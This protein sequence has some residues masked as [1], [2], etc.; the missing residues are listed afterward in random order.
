MSRRKKHK[1]FSQRGVALLAVAVCMTIIAVIASGFDQ[2]TRTD[3]IAATT[4]RDRMRA[5]F[6]ARS[7]M[8]LGELVIR[9]QKDLIDNMQVGDIQI[10]D[11]LI[12]GEVIGLF[13][14]SEDNLAGSMTMQYTGMSPEMVKGLGLEVGHF[15]L[16]IISEGG[17]INVNCANGSQE[18]R[19]VLKDRLDALF[20]PQAYDQ[21]FENETADGYRRTR[22]EQAAAIIDYIDRD[23]SLF[24]SPGT[25]E[26]YGYRSLDDDYEAKNNY[27]DTVGELQMVRGIDDRFWAVFGDAFTVYGSCKVNIKAVT[28]PNIIASIILLAAKDPQD[29]VVQDPKRLY[30]LAKHVAGLQASSGFLS[31]IG[32]ALTGAQVSELEAFANKVANPQGA[33][34]SMF[35]GLEGAPEPAPLVGEDGIRIE[36]VE[37]D[38]QKLGR[39]AEAGPRRI[40]RI[41]SSAMIGQIQVTI[42]GVW[43]TEVQNQ[44]PR[45]PGYDKGTW[46]LWREL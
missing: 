43:D 28:D 33:L 9:V 35:A 18:T 19:D 12:L 42:T 6:L 17:R 36:G 1:L 29:P 16:A 40:Y 14:G 26:D 7:A 4:A 20:F 8:N 34:Q 32:A 30:A 25:P 3:Y 23:R 11:P 46:V 24:D 22:S 44:N 37:L 21:L 27:I 2:N 39:I 45:G 38:M 5:H 10:T 15:N 13:G 31:L 41:E